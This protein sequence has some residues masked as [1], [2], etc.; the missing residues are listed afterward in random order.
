[1]DVPDTLTEEWIERAISGLTDEALTDVV[2]TLQ[3]ERGPTPGH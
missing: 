2:A 3:H 1:M